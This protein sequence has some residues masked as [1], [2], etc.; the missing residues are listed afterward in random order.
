MKGVKRNMLGVEKGN[1]NRTYNVFLGSC[2]V[3][4]VCSPVWARSWRTTFNSTQ[5]IT[6]QCIRYIFKIKL[7]CTTK[8]CTGQYFMAVISLETADVPD[9]H[10][11]QLPAFS[12]LKG[13]SRGLHSGAWSPRS[14]VR[15]DDLAWGPAKDSQCIGSP[16]CKAGAPLARRGS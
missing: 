15:R 14:S 2:Y 9:Q 6:T 5:R 1:P 8:E 7:H 4:L 16:L 10:Q 12:T 11:L 13:C 3:H